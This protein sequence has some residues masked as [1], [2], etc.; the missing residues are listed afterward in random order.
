MLKK[1]E[2]IDLNYIDFEY[3]WGLQKEP[4]VTLPY[5]GSNYYVKMNGEVHLKLDITWSEILN[6]NNLII[7]GLSWSGTLSA[8]RSG[9]FSIRGKD[10]HCYFTIKPKLIFLSPSHVTHIKRSELVLPS[11]CPYPNMEGNLVNNP[12]R[13][14]IMRTMIEIDREYGTFL[15]RKFKDEIR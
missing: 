8:I 9:H 1:A 5:D 13:E 2:K 11:W 10:G 15:Y 12:T 14:N 3:D 6:N 4:K 7:F